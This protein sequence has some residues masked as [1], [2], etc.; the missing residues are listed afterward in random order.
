[1][2]HVT[3][4][5]SPAKVT[6]HYGQPVKVTLRYDQKGE[7]GVG[8]SSVALDEQAHLIVTYDDGKTQ[9][10]GAALGDVTSIKDGIDYSYR[11]I[12]TSEANVT[13][14][15][16]STK[17]NAEKAQQALQD[18]QSA[19][20][21]GVNNINTL[22]TEKMT[23]MTNTFNS[24]LTRAKANIDQWERDAEDKI[25]TERTYS[26]EQIKTAHDD[27]MV[28]IERSVNKA[29]AWAVSE[30][31]PDREPDFE[32]PT[33]LT[34][35]SRSWALYSKKKVQESYD[36]LKNIHDNEKNVA[37]MKNDVNKLLRRAQASEANAKASETNAENSASAAASSA[38]A[39]KTSETNAKS[40]ETAAKTSETNAAA[41]AS[42]ATAKAETVTTQANNAKTSATNSANSAS[43]SATSAS[44]AKTSETNAKASETASKKWAVSETSPDGGTDTDSGT[45]KTQSSRT[46]ALE[47]KSSAESASASAITSTTQASSAT[48]SA[49]SANT[50]ATSASNSATSA[51]SSATAARN[52][53][54]A[55]A[56]SATNAN[57]S[58]TQASEYKTSASDSATAAASSA[59]SASESA[60]NARTA[61]NTANTA[62][63]SASTSATNA[64]TSASNA[65]KSEI[66]A[67]TA[68][69]AAEK[70]RD[71]AN[72]AVNKLTGAMK[73]AGQ[74]DNYSDLADVTKNKGDVWNIVNADPSH[75]IKAG[76]N[77]A[78]NG[79]DWDNLSGVV[80]LSAYAEKVDYQKVITSAT[81]NGATITFN[82]KD[83]T[84][85]TATVNNVASATAATNDAKGQKIDT[86]YEKIADASNVHTSLQNSI[87]TK[88]DK[89]TFD[90]TPTVGST[91]PVT[92]AGIKAALDGKLGKNE[93]AARATQDG[94]GNTISTTY[95]SKA[96]VSA[97]ISTKL[98]VTATAY[99][100]TRDGAGNNI[101]DTYATKSSLSSYQTKLTFDST[102]TANSSNP[103][104]SDGIKTTLDTKLD[105]TGTAVSASKLK[106]ART[107]SLTGNA[108][109]STSFDG[110]G[111]VSI[112]T[113]VN[114]S[115]HAV[116]ADTLKSSSATE[117]STVA[118]PVWLSLE[119]NNTKQTVSPNL[120]YTCSTKTLTATNFK[121]HLA[122]NADSATT[123]DSATNADKVDG[124]HESSFLRRRGEAATTGEDT[125]WNQIGIKEYHG[126]LPKG[127]SGTYNYGAVVSL[128]GNDT[129]LDIWYN[130]MCSA[131][132]DGLWY[133]SGYGTDQKPW[134]CL[135][136]SNN[137]TNYTPTKTG[138][139]ASG[140]WG[141]SISGTAAKA[142]SDASGNNIANTY[143]TKANTYTKAE[144]D[145]KISL[146]WVPRY[147]LYERSALPMSAKTSITIN[148]MALTINDSTYELKDAE[149][150]ALN[151]SSSWD[152]ETY[153][154]A[155]NR[156]G[157]DFYI[158]ACIPDSGT[159][160]KFILSANSTVP[161]GYTA[162]NSRKIGGFHCL[163]A[164]V[165]TISG[166]SLSG[167]IT[168]DIL[169]ASVWDLLHRCKGENEGMVYDAYD[170]VWIGIYLL[171]YDNGR[172]VSR[173]NGVILDGESTPK[174]HGLWFTET[175][176]KQKMRLPYLHEFFTALKGCQE[177]VN[178][179]GSKDWNT[180]GGHV[181]TNN[182]RCIS[183]IG[184]E[185]PTGFMWQLS[186]NYGM[187]GGSEWGQSA[188]DSQ[189]DSV[190]RGGTYGNLWLP[191]VGGKWNSG[192]NCGSRSV[193]GS[194]VAA[195]RSAVI[196]A[197][198]ASESRVVIL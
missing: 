114:E 41:S 194:N 68:Q 191:L 127:V 76:D 132:N 65:S 25:H 186:N 4:S 35:S 72:S 22:T 44:N 29:E 107:I 64:S 55:A 185:D 97:L 155:A 104:T 66:A 117:T 133:R 123:A 26:L 2:N 122:G 31:T 124:Y 144:V 82:H 146:V 164:S 57:N 71:D 182:V 175:L 45:G 142:T 27:A 198:P 50:S 118:R 145:N 63:S 84:T 161:T 129:R 32:S 165:G 16:A 20:A 3:V 11:K 135:I 139:G 69:A 119:N 74:V 77:V 178:I 106:T 95:A 196:G 108:T 130:H 15:E 14:L 83:G 126:K 1:M 156:A 58:E 52:S 86:T 91:N 109:G 128:P 33:G 81:A 19:S 9:D 6:L 70:A 61:M 24:L 121:G 158:Y 187:A 141:I 154:T 113:T 92:S 36:I 78:W 40:S 120:T 10:A 173:F 110:S 67:K 190:N 184:L 90:T 23:Y 102:P 47:S 21:S 96:D 8:I 167:Y 151:S 112:N 143:A 89:L 80:D 136:D 140:T 56:A 160:P 116:L 193:D 53:A 131:N 147:N 37:N 87:N 179:S 170:D 13:K 85:S 39:A 5:S 101:A 181:Y 168:G 99:A 75:G 62:A 48:A 138:S 17:T 34:Q 192:S 137:Y 38:I 177:Q 43:E 42:T 93:T 111:D 171:S 176:A 30:T 115:K 60:T 169:P 153:V 12:Q 162:Y 159:E 195:H 149:V 189:V 183:N 197:R 152:S 125:L 148:P 18:T 51:A 54:T 166:H 157:K 188:Y 46:W 180:T 150:L 94:A 79:T 7:R 59:S 73:Y 100:A 172:A 103:V 134:A 105:K 163:C 174:T 49:N 28:D 88:Q 98:G